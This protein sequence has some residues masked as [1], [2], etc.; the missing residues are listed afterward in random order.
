M[1]RFGPML[2]HHGSGWVGSVNCW[3]GLGDVK[4]T[5]VHLGFSRSLKAAT[6]EFGLRGVLSAGVDCLAECPGGW[7]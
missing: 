4:W 7:E 6:V 1:G 3:V 2:E 5:R